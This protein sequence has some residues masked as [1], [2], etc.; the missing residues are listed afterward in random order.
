ME[1]CGDFDAISACFGKMLH[2]A[3][4]G[5][6]NRSRLAECATLDELP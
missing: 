1:I 5:I 6:F 3:A 4:V 2:D